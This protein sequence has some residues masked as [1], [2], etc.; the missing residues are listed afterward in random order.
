MWAVSTCRWCRT[1]KLTEYKITVSTCRWCGM[2]GLTEYKIT[3]S[4]CSWC[5][6]V[7]L[8]KYRITVSTCSWCGTVKLTKY[9]IT[10]LTCSQCGIVKHTEYRITVSTCS[11]CVMHWQLKSF[12]V[13]LWLVVD[14]HVLVVFT[15]EVIQC[16]PVPDWWLRGRWC[17]PGGDLL[18]WWGL[19]PPL[20]T[21]LTP[22]KSCFAKDTRAL[23]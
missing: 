15:A 13:C 4:T 10:M 22:A 14:V 7:G 19:A 21:C 2:V 3:V 5:G 8:T 12:S 17:S 11:W 16:V 23:C 6:T 20:L 9:R 18:Q 1:V